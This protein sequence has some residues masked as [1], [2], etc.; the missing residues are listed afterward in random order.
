MKPTKGFLH[1]LEDIFTE[2]DYHL[3]YE[4]GNFKSGYC[5]LKSQKVIIVNK[6]YP[7]EGKINVL[8]DIL[9]HVDIDTTNLSEKN[10]S[11]YT[12]ITQ[13]QLKL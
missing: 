7:V 1:K 6:Y 12:E 2:S 9:K 8:S 11:L 5:V 10:K 3:R 4:K 13:E